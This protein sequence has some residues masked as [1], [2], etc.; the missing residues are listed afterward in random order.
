MGTLINN[1]RVLTFPDRI[2]H[3]C[4]YKYGICLSPLKAPTYDVRGACDW[5]DGASTWYRH[6][7]H[8]EGVVSTPQ[9][10]KRGSYPPRT[11][12]DI[13]LAS[14]VLTL[15][16]ALS[17]TGFLAHRS[18][19]GQVVNRLTTSVDLPTEFIHLYISNCISSCENIKDKYM[20]V[21]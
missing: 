19:A 1:H 9:Y 7:I 12:A 6:G 8:R 11:I 21:R 4:K 15:S 5:P 18:L 2:V 17:L 10:L 16:P 3:I 13:W 14:V 20:Q